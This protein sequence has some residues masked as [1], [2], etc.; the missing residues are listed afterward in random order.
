VNVGRLLLLVDE[1]F[2]QRFGKEMT[3]ARYVLK[4]QVRTQLRRFLEQYQKPMLERQPITLLALEQKHEIQRGAFRLNGKL[5]RV[6]RRGEIVHILDYK[7][8]NPDRIH[9]V[10]L[11]KLDSEKRE[12]WKS[13]IASLQLP[14]Y[15]ML[16][17]TSNGVPIESL[18]PAYVKLGQ[19]IIDDEIET[20][21]FEEMALATTGYQQVGRVVDGLLN[22]IIN[23]EIPFSPTENVEKDCTYCPFQ[24]ICGTQWAGAGI[25][26]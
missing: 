21:L 26:R 15:A 1:R 24:S 6:E 12:T 22:E 17:S 18:V 7:T 20:P 25:N 2:D 19:S 23:S 8:G 11:G 10:E 9:G 13:A 5:D 14:V 3:G 4:Q 16:Y